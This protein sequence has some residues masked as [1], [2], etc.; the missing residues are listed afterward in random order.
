ML[1][2]KVELLMTW[3]KALIMG[4]GP[5]I[6]DVLSSYEKKSNLFASYSLQLPFITGLPLYQNFQ[7]INAF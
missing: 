4:Q 6:V 3:L 2:T 1:A 5:I 7:K